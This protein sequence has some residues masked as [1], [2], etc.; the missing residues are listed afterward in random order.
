LPEILTAVGLKTSPRS[1]ASSNDLKAYCE[2]QEEAAAKEE[3]VAKGKQAHGVE[4]LANDLNDT[5]VNFNIGSPVKN[6]E[7]NKNA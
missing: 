3:A 6:P 5:H 1:E 7:E 2:K 4:D